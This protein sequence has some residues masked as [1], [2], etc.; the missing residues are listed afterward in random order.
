MKQYSS[1]KLDKATIKRA[2]IAIAI[3]PQIDCNTLIPTTCDEL[4]YKRYFALFSSFA[5][6]IKAFQ[7]GIKP[8]EYLRLYAN[9]KAT[10]YVVNS[11]FG[12]IGDL[13]ECCV[14]CIMRKRVNLIHLTDIQVKPLTLKHDTQKQQLTK[15]DINAKNY[16]FEIGHNGKTFTEA[17]PDNN[18]E[19]TFTSVIYGMFSHDELNDICGLICSGEIKQG[20]KTLASGLYVWIDKYQFEFDI[21]N[22][23][24]GKGITYK[25]HINASQVVYNDSKLNSFIRYMES[26]TVIPTLQEFAKDSEL[27]K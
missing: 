21:N 13:I 17:T 25:P 11:D 5:A 19:G 27:L 26:Q 12:A 4:T 16:A 18:M 1:I 24:R 20:F 9:W 6:V 7:Q 3:N 10:E 22:V 2:R 14:R 15:V 8:L 23:S